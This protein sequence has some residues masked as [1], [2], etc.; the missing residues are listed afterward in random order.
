M[1]LALAA[2]MSAAVSF[3]SFAGEWKQDYVGSWYDNGNGTFPA[4]TWQWIDSDHNGV[5][6]RYY[7]DEMCIRDRD[8][9]VLKGYR[10]VRNRFHE[11]QQ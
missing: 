7:F 5:A 6:E 11:K 4:G 3:L 1:V 10:A 8:W 2:G 9:E